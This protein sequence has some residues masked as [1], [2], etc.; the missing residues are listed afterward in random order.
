VP[1]W[2]G[3]YAPIR[4]PQA[5]IDKLSAAAHQAMHDAGVT[6]RLGDIGTEGVGSSPAE[7][8]T[9]TREQFAL[10]RKIVRDNPALLSGQ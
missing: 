7:L 2:T 3:L 8:D 4:T 10:Y 6:K 1:F 9:A 5:V